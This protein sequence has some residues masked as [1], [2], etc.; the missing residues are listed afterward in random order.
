MLKF[1]RLFSAWYESFCILNKFKSPFF[2]DSSH[3]HRQ[4]NTC[5]T[6]PGPNRTVQWIESVQTIRLNVDSDEAQQSL[7]SNFRR[8]GTRFCL[9]FYKKMLFDVCLS[10]FYLSR[11]C[12][13]SRFCPDF[14]CPCPSTSAK[15]PRSIKVNDQENLN[16]TA[17]RVSIRDSRSNEALTS[18]SISSFDFHQWLNFEFQT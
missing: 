3:F 9:E 5:E 2:D 1:V 10:W 6:E 13:L 11:F 17:Q 4:I 12:R 8:S 15:W 14:Y 16:M 7:A 18:L